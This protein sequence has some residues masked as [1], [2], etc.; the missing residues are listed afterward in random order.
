MKAG[1]D[2]ELE[3]LLLKLP[4]NL[5]SRVIAEESER[6]YVDPVRKRH[7]GGNMAIYCI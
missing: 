2:Q 7:S 5:L 6:R 3:V 1:R 4:I